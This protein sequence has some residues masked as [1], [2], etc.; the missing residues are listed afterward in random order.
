M[1]SGDSNYSIILWNVNDRK[2][3]KRFEEQHSNIVN[4]VVWNPNG[5]YFAS[6]GKDN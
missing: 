4:T 1:V 2:E 5:R 3:I 6:G